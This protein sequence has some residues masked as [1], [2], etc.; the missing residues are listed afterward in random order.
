MIRLC[1]IYKSLGD[2]KLKNINLTIEDNEYFVI[3]GPTGTGKTVILEVIAG[4]YKPDH[5]EVWLNER[6]VTEEYPE[7]RHIGFVYQ[8]Y[9]LFPHLNVEENILFALKLKK[10][11][12]KIMKEKLER[13]ATLLNIN[14]LLQRYPATLSGGE[15]QR[16]AIAR[17]LVAEPD[18]LLLDEPLSALDPRSKEV[19]QQELK[20][21]HRQIKTTTIHITHDF[22]EALVLADRMGI[23][24]NGE[25]VQVGSPED[26]FHKPC[27]QF[28]ATFVGME[29]IFNGIISDESDARQVRIGP[30]QLRV[31][32]NLLGKV[33]VAIRSEDIII[34]EDKLSSSAQNILPASITEIVPRGPFFKLF[35]DA[36][37][38]LVALVTRQAIDE[39]RLE[40][41]KNV[42]AVF[43][44]AAVHVF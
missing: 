16:T 40:P 3:L 21:I 14:H 17:A 41:G 22:N 42:W 7:S 44:T 8:D 10:T 43:K 9:M 38:P 12:A 30:V 20:Q 6:N 11:P 27:S 35:L 34:A 29:N 5:G 36:G 18:V 15:Q 4:M 13:M 37:I 25:I 28:V 26:V 32:S 1:N 23:M 33:R 31:A 19:F 24:C 39:M 2:F